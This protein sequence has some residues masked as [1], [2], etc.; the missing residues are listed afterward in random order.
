MNLRHK[1]IYL[2]FVLGLWVVLFWKDGSDLEYN[3]MMV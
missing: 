2:Q 1:E 3:E